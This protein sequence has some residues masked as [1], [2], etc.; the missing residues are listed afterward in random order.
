MIYLCIILDSMGGIVSHKIILFYIATNGMPMI[1]FN[2][3]DLNQKNEK[4]SSTET[5]S[6][7]S[8]QKEKKVENGNKQEVMEPTMMI[9]TPIFFSGVPKYCYNKMYKKKQKPFTEREGDWICN[10]C[11]NLNFAF[12]VECN[13]C[14]LPKERSNLLLKQFNN[15]NLFQSEK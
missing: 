11:K 9:G 4:T 5:S 8:S 3:K 12:R 10:S 14:K 7:D 6:E 15:I 13:R 2:P 1:A